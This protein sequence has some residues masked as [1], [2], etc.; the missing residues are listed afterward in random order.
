ML[1]ALNLV[2][3]REGSGLVCRCFS[4]SVNK[5]SFGLAIPSLFLVY[6]TRGPI[7]EGNAV[8]L[9]L[10]PKLSTD[11][12]GNAFTSCMLIYLANLFRISESKL[13]KIKAVAHILKID[14]KKYGT[15]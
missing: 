11:T 13:R 12:I 6:V 3:V 14:M 10:S 2:Y 8:Y 7:Y 4:L 15:F 5:Y 1:A 9:R